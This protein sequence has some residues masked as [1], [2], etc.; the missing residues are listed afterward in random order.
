M[1]TEYLVLVLLGGLAGGF[2]SGL[3]GFGTGITAL[4]IWL[5]VLSPTV[6][7]TLV[8]VCSIGGQ[9]QTLPKIWHAVEVRRVAPFII[10]GLLGVPI[11]T[12]LLASVEVRTFKLAI[13]ILLLAYSLH[14]LLHRAHSGYQWGG[15]TA[16]SAIGLGGGIL[17]GLAG[18]SGPLPT[19]WADIRGW[20][21]EQKRSLFQVFNL[22][23]LCAALVS[24]FA[25]GLV[26]RDLVV[27]AAVALP[28]TFIG[29]WIGFALYTRL[30]ERRFKEI[31]LVLLCVSGIA[32]VW[33][34]F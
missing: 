5:Y 23:I 6:A 30:S 8:I 28:G 33:T 31:I 29:S 13:G 14:S 11:G 10:P 16:D 24:H 27:A 1:G 3:A 15:R 2:V 12:M 17:G 21:K 4:G 20:S 25:A 22:T 9:L 26:T 34:N 32:L 19:V 18:L 7:A